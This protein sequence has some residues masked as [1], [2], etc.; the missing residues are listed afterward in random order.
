MLTSPRTMSSRNHL[1]TGHNESVWNLAWSPNG[2]ALASASSDKV[3]RIW[4]KLEDSAP[5]VCVALLDGVHSRTIRRVSWSPNGKILATCG[6]DGIIALWGKRED[7][8]DYE[9]LQTLEGH[10]NE[11]KCVAWSSCGTFLASCGRDKTVWIWECIY[12]NESLLDVDWECVAVLNGHSQDVKFL[13]WLPHSSIL[14]SCSYDDSIRIWDCSTDDEWECVQILSEHS[15]TVWELDFND[16]GTQMASCDG[17]GNLVIWDKQSAYEWEV[18]HQLKIHTRPIYT[19]SWA[20]DSSSIVT[21]GGDDRI[22]TSTLTNGSWVSSN[23]L[24]FKGSG[25]INSLEWNPC[26][27]VLAIAS[28]DGMVRVEEYNK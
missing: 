28:D 14:F 6:F 19:L 17:D 11:V 3:V 13:K 15:S 18:V 23:V 24:L 4:K 21:G 5:Y 20:P 10:E 25:D 16:Q 2:K 12:A 9:C 26:S 22:V 27:D 7:C 8:G 1:L